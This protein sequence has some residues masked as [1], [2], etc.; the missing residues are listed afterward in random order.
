LDD[1]TGKFKTIAKRGVTDSTF[2]VDSK[3]NALIQTY[4]YQLISYDSIC[5]DSAIS[6]THETI[7]LSCS[8][9]TNAP[10]I[11][12]LSW[13][14]YKGVTPE[15]Y[16]IYIYNAETVVDIVHLAN[17]GNPFFSY[18]Y[19]NHQTGYTYRIG[20][21]LKNPVYTGRL[22]SD[23]GPFSQSLSNMAESELTDNA[24]VPD[25]FA[26]KVYPSP[27]NSRLSIKSDSEIT[28]VEIYNLLGQVVLKTNKTD[29]PIDVSGLT[30]G[31]YEMVIHSHEQVSKARFVK[32]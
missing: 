1:A 3:A 23:S 5:H 30:V 29:T 27:T 16:N 21:D 22:K 32:E 2:V 12:E 9:S 26:V 19:N 20:F 10:N 24:L 7:H 8:Q 31:I 28:Q 17:N 6:D 11:V 18:S 13:N 15:V 25:N 4:S 14:T